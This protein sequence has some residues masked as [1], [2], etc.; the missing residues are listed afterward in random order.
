MNEDTWPIGAILLILLLFLG[1]CIHV[2]P[3]TKEEQYKEAL[4]SYA[5]DKNLCE[6]GARHAKYDSSNYYYKYQG[7]Y[8]CHMAYYWKERIEKLEKELEENN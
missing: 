3:W 5:A 4:R 6:S 8:Y 7:Q 2:V 1:T